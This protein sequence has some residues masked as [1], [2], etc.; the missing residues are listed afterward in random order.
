LSSYYSGELHPICVG[1]CTPTQMATVFD[2]CIVIVLLALLWCVAWRGATLAPVVH[3][4]MTSVR[5]C[6]LQGECCAL[7]GMCAVRVLVCVCCACAVWSCRVGGEFVIRSFDVELQE[8][9]KSGRERQQRM[10][11][12]DKIDVDAIVVRMPC[13]VS[14]RPSPSLSPFSPAGVRRALLFLAPEVPLPAMHLHVPCPG[15][16]QK[17]VRHS[18]QWNDELEGWKERKNLQ[19][20]RWVLCP[21]HQEPLPHTTHTSHMLRC[22]CRLWCLGGC[23]CGPL[24]C[25]AHVPRFAKNIKMRAYGFY[26]M[27]AFVAF[28]VI[29]LI[30]GFISPKQ[31]AAAVW[32]EWTIQYVLGQLES[33]QTMEFEALCVTCAPMY[34][35]RDVR[36]CGGWWGGGSSA[37]AVPADVIR[38]YCCVRFLFWGSPLVFLATEPCFVLVCCLVVVVVVDSVVVDFL[39]VA[40]GTV[41]ACCLH[42]YFWLVLTQFL[43]EVGL[44]MAAAIMVRWPQAALVRSKDLGACPNRR[45]CGGC[46]ALLHHPRGNPCFVVLMSCT[47]PQCARHT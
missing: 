40:A 16:P 32:P 13:A 7:F 31:P 41:F 39:V 1:K 47:C 45:H 38:G 20:E 26:S 11:K 36:V 19:K 21:P 24:F 5:V 27:Y 28:L 33:L 44:F 10:N 15:C 37:C 8:D 9:I 30:V 34:C 2:I 42:S 3:V 29:L 46:P 17:S 25:T 12:R 22:M 18:W 35:P 4:H 23:I 6:L 14:F 43:L